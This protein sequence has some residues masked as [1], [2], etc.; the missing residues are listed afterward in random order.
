MTLNLEKFA[1]WVFNYPTHEPWCDK[2]LKGMCTYPNKNG[3][4]VFDSIYFA[5]FKAKFLHFRNTYGATEGLLRFICDLDDTW[6]PR[7]ENYII[8]AKI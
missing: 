6:T 4:M 5:H 3:E 7:L 8:N 2:W 1:K